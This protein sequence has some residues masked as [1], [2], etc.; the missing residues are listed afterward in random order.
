MKTPKVSII[1]PNH[2]YGKYITDAI[3]SV[4][5]QTLSE[6]ECIIID[7][8]SDDNSVKIINKLIKDDNRFLLIKFKEKRGVS[9]AR[10]AGLDVARGK[11]IA[12]LDSDDC[13]TE[14]ALEMLVDMAEAMSA[15]VAG[16]QALI[17]PDDF[18]YRP[19]NNNTWTVGRSWIEDNPTRFL[20]APKNYNWCW[21]WRRIYHRDLLKN[22]R[23]FPEFV[24]AGDDIAFMLD[25]S[26]RTKRIVETENISVYHRFHTESVM[27]RPFNKG[28]F[29]WFPV[30]FK[31]VRDNI[32]DKYSPGFLRQFYRSMFM[33]LTDMTIV[34]PKR[35][36]ELYEDGRKVVTEAC[37]YIPL[38]Y[39]RPRQRI[40]CRFLRWIK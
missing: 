3:K 1:I 34:K 9:S 20:T 2:N 4:M 7:D 10:N 40:L 11:W 27:Q 31:Y 17:V 29:D 13:Y 19:S 22:V 33:Y 21:V 18:K 30:F 15:Q 12:F 5:A 39:L 28:M 38:R 24:V 32:C 14:F 8:A 16:A 6:W 26:Y 25:L 35:T 37:R 23:F 36:G